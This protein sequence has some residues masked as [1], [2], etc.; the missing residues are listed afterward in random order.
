MGLYIVQCV[1]TGIFKIDWASARTPLI[2]HNI[3]QPKI[4]WVKR[5]AYCYGKKKELDALYARVQ[6]NV[7]D[8][9]QPENDYG[10]HPI[11]E[12]INARFFEQKGIKANP[13]S[14][15]IESMMGQAVIVEWDAVESSTYG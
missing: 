14:A 4:R 12:Y 3:Y 11:I 5:S 8:W 6:A 2:F 1:D 13:S 9:L 15:E 7:G 10:Q